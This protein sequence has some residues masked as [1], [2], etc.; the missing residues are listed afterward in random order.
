MN[1]KVVITESMKDKLS[2]IDLSN[3]NDSELI[4]SINETNIAV[5]RLENDKI[6]VKESLNG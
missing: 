3:K 1:D 2:D 4:Q 6:I 5:A